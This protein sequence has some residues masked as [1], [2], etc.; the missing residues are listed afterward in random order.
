MTTLNRNP[1]GVNSRKGA[2]GQVQVAGLAEEVLGV[3]DRCRRET[4][5]TYSESGA[6]APDSRDPLNDVR[7]YWNMH[8]GGVIISVLQ[9]VG[10]PPLA[11]LPQA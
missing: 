10:L 3:G 6:R 1:D 11:S 7:V 4:R 8:T 9:L 2:E 5:G